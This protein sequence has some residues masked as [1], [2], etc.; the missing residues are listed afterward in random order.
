MRI[1]QYAYFTVKST[2]MSPAELDV[3]EYAH[4]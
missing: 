2:Q 3:D 4:G 1:S